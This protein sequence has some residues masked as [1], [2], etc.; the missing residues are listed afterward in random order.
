[1]KLLKYLFGA[2]MLMF[3]LTKDTNEKNI[4]LQHKK[5]LRDYMYY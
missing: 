1:M 2:M 4:V 5:A 3:Y